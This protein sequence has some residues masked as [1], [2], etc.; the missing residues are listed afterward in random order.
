M[1]DLV[2]QE[3]ERMVPEL[4]DFVQRGILSQ[5]SSP[6]LLLLHH[7]LLPSCGHVAPSTHASTALTTTV[8]CFCCGVM[9]DEVRSI[10]RSRGDFEYRLQR[11]VP[12]ITDYLRYIEFEMNFDKLRRKLKQRAHIT[13]INKYDHIMTRRIFFIYERC[14]SHC[15]T[16][17]N[18]SSYSAS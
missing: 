12:S 3:L 1:G 9:Q 18:T 7:A 2:Q 5:V 10:V 11:R 17:L 15:S 13:Q 6:H 16:K 8:A 14:L 4:E